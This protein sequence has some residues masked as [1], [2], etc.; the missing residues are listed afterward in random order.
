MP[1][2]AGDPWLT[3][4]TDRRV[5]MGRWWAAALLASVAIILACVLMNV[6]V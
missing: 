6:F 1:A 5:R 2:A 4:H 3:L